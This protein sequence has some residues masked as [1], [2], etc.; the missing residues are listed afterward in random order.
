MNK[1]CAN[2]PG[3]NSRIKIECFS[4][5]LAIF[6]SFCSCILFGISKFTNETTCQSALDAQINPND[7][8]SA[9]LMRLPGIGRGKAEAI[10]S[11][12]EQQAKG[13]TGQAF[14]NCA[15]L[16]NVRGIGPKTVEKICEWLRFE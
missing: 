16:E 4:F 11:Y 15:D 9:S 7:A 14:G 5:V 2:Q 13:N 6:I 1:E 10:I 3:D 8:T 12:R